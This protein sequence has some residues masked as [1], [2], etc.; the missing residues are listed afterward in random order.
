MAYTGLDHFIAKLRFSRRIPVHPQRIA[1]V[2]PRLR[3]STRRFSITPATKFRTASASTIRSK[4]ACAAAGGASAPNITAPL[5]LEAVAIRSRRDAR[6]AR[7]SAQTRAGVC[8]RPIASSRRV[9]ASSLTWPSSAVDPIL[10]VLRGS[11]LVSSEMESD[12]HQKRIPVEA[13]QAMLH[14]SASVNSFTAASN[15]E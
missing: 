3:A 7:A 12:Q 6:R 10:E 8:A 1:R 15:S 4:T 11:G 13:L 5:P 2:R 14:A 9:A